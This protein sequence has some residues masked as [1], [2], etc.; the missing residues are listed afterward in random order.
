MRSAFFVGGGCSPLAFGRMIRRMP[1]YDL[2]INP[3]V[4]GGYYSGRPALDH[5]ELHGVKLY[6]DGPV[7]HL[8]A[9]LRPFPDMPSKRWPVG[10]NAAE[11]DLALWGIRTLSVEGWAT[12]MVGVFTLEHIAEHRL[13]FS[14][15]SDTT[16]IRGECMGVRIDS[17]TGYIRTSEP[18]AP[19]NGPAEPLGNPGAGGGPPSV[20]DSFGVKS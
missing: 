17:I 8:L 3:K 20:N 11:I 15:L 16:A 6:D 19:P 14:F 5:M 4:V 12:K 7:L 2:T 18:G 13:R 9:Y 1:W 10:A